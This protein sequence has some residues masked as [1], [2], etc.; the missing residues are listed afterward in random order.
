MTL[1][2]QL[3]LLRIGLALA[4]FMALV[5][6]SPVLHL[7]ALI[8]FIAAVI[9]D[10]IDGYVAR[11]TN[12]VSA[13][14]KVAD[15]IADKILVIGAFIALIHTRE[16]RIPLWGVF[17][18]VA[19]DLLIGGVR[20]LARSPG[21]SPAAGHWGQWEMGLQAVRRRHADHPRPARERARPARLGP[22]A[23][24]SPDGA[25]CRGD[26]ALGLR[27]FPSIP[28]APREV[29]GMMDAL[30]TALAT[31]L[32]LSYIPSRLLRLA[33]RK[34][35]SKWT[36][37]GLVGTAE[38]LLLV[39][40]MPEKPFPLALTLCFGIAVSCWICGQAERILGTHDDPRIVLDEVVGFLVA[41]AFLPKSFA[42]MASA[43][44]L[45]R[46]FDTLKPPPCRWLERLPGGAGVVADDVGAGLLANL[47]LQ[48]ATFFWP[49]LLQ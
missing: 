34:H 2:N 23:A 22:G 49:G 37:A 48:T 10:W 36:G 46:L 14:G 1:A 40:F 8:M 9:T 29:L 35:P 20:V 18:I 5:Q 17:L 6:R 42:A 7:A 45:F 3:T 41:A 44:V 24:L 26:L 27:L 11:A 30:W 19:R 31:G 16:L 39:P 4:M 13:F 38:G 21:R 32:Y 15:P 25:L 33:R 28:E 12:S 43:F 47:A